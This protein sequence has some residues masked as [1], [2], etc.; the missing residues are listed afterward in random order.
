MSN[1]EAFTL[2]LL[3]CGLIF[4]AAILWLTVKL[5]V[6]TALQATPVIAKG[7]AKSTPAVYAG[8]SKGVVTAASAVQRSGFH[9]LVAN[10]ANVASLRCITTLQAALYGRKKQTEEELAPVDL[11]SGWDQYDAPAYQRKGVVLSF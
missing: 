10:A 3:I 8:V 5:L 4:C 6:K 11:D 9:H 7:I 1:V 2:Q